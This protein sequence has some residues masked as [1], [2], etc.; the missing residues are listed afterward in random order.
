MDHKFFGNALPRPPTQKQYVTS[1]PSTIRYIKVSCFFFSNQSPNP[2][3]GG[4]CND[5]ENL[6]HGKQ[7]LGLTIL[8]RNLG[9]AYS[10]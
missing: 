5:P 7:G 10:F 6:V 1:H 9:L 3:T 8:I 2:S 4:E